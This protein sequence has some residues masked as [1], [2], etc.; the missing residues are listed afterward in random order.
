MISRHEQERYAEHGLTPGRSVIRLVG[1][2]GSHILTRLFL[3]STGASFEHDSLKSNG[4]LVTEDRVAWDGIAR[5]SLD[6]GD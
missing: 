6:C 2:G 5:V 3:Y 1:L 4:Y